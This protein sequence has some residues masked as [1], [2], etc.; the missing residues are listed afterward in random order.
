MPKR[1]ALKDTIKDPLVKMAPDDYQS[2]KNKVRVQRPVR[3]VGK[4]VFIATMAVSFICGWVAG[5]FVRII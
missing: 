4:V 3:K 1:R 5:R 2:K